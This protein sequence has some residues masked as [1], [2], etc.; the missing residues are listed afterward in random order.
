[1]LILKKR[2]DIRISR[3]LSPTPKDA[4]WQPSIFA[5]RTR[6]YSYGPQHNPLFG[7]ASGGVYHTVPLTRIPGELLPHHF[8]LTPHLNKTRIFLSHLGAGRY[9]FC[10]TFLPPAYSPRYPTIAGL[11]ALRSPDFP[12]HRGAAAAY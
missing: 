4:G 9:I 7:L 1:M 6:D 3:I 11:P 5:A 2:N 10:G 12:L 8:T